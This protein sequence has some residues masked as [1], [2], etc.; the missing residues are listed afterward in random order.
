PGGIKDCPEDKPKGP[1][2][3]LL[4]FAANGALGR[5]IYVADPLTGKSMKVVGE[6]GDGHLD[7][8]EIWDDTNGNGQVD[9]GEDKGFI[10]HID[11][12]K[13]LGIALTPALTGGPAYT[14]SFFAD[15]RTSGGERYGLHTFQFKHDASFPAVLSPANAVGYQR[16]VAVGEMLPGLGTVNALD[17]YD[18]INA[19]GQVACSTDTASGEAIVRATPPLQTSGQVLDALGGYSGG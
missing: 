5:G 11:L 14:V 2:S 12:D 17:T 9:P 15:A 16:V 13:H 8:N 4:V 3:G 7:A 18:P 19:T 10:T 6:T 1:F